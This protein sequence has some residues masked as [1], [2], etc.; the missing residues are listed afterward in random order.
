MGLAGGVCVTL[1]AGDYNRYLAEVS[2]GGERATAEQEASSAYAAGS[3]LA[4]RAL[5]GGAPLRL[6]L[7]LNHAVLCH[8]HLGQPAQ[9]IAI[10]QVSCAARLGVV[11]AGPRSCS[12]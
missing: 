1:R 4:K 10:A 3:A 11:G 12:C 8:H 6:S 5:A 7:A 9:A 2:N